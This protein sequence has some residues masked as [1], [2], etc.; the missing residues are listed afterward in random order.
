VVINIV[1]SFFVANDIIHNAL[2]VIYSV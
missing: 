1:D 2:Y